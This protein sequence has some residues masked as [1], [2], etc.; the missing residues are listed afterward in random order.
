MP[1]NPASADP[2]DRLGPSLLG[3]RWSLRPID[4]VAAAD[5][6]R[7]VGVSDAVARLLAA[8]GVTPEV[9]PDFLKPTLRALM[10][11]PSRL[12]D[13]DA[14]AA[15]LVAAIEAGEPIAVFGDYDV[16]GGT[17]SA[18]LVRYFRALGVEILAYIP[19]RAAEGYG[20]NAPA[21]LRLA[22]QGAK[23]VITV[24]CGITAFAPLQAAREAGLDVIVVDHHKAEPQLPAAA[25]VVNPNRL[26][27]AS[28]LKQLAA[29]GVAFLLVVALNRALRASGWFARRGMAEPDLRQWLDLVALGT[30]ADV[31]PLT[32]LNRAFVVQG[33]SVLARGENIGLAALRRVARANDA[34]NAYHLGF[35]LG[36]RVNAGGRIGQSDLGVRLM[37]TADPD[38]ATALALRLD[39]LNRA[40]QD[41]EAAVLAESIEQVEREGLDAAPLIVAASA[42]WHAGVIGIVAA[43]LK[44][45][46]GKPACVIAIDGGMARG[47]GRSV[48][49]V[50]LGRAVLAARE[51]GLLVNGGGHPMAAGFTVTEDRIAA[52]G[53]FLGEHVAGQLAGGPRAAELVLDGVLSPRG[54]TPA[55]VDELAAVGPFGAGNEE[56]RFAVMNAQVVRAD[57]VGSGHVRCILSGPGG[58]RLKAIAFRSADSELGLGLLGAKGQGLHVAGV[59]RADTWQGRVDAQLVIEDAVG[60][61]PPSG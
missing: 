10:P 27:D 9:A 59:V 14:A 47:S 49:G 37:T 5:L 26:D 6:A 52:L 46:Y 50:D 16:D 58:G 30:V 55:L 44:E 23:V 42:T 39:E 28:G 57:I 36:P 13:M 48:A 35:L 38:E 8:R 4:E 20:P 34:P 43:R 32:G 40:R 56:P 11:D 19:D 3:R 53:A 24:D 31:V 17:S 18:L 2:F 60:A 1:A 54:V 29:V 15:R 45:R 22:G 61:G 25:A 7:A 12:I 21:L 41:I 51:A 33:L